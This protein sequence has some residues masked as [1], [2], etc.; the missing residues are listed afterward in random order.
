VAEGTDE[1]PWTKPDDFDVKPTGPLPK[2]GRADRSFFLVVMGDG[3]VVKVP[4]TISEA[5]LRNAINRHDG[6]VLGQ[7]W[8]R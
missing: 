7:D 8:P 4:K 6:L 5:T 2:L 3:T 1:V